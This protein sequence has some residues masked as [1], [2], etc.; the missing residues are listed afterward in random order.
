MLFLLSIIV[1]VALAQ[2]YTQS[3][4]PYPINDGV[5]VS[6][7]LALLVIGQENWSKSL[8]KTTYDYSTV[9]SIVL[10]VL[11]SILLIVE[12]KSNGGDSANS[13]D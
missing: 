8:F 2:N 5:G 11:Y 10:L 7:L 12:K 4:L 9:V 3:L 13:T 6:N 1:N